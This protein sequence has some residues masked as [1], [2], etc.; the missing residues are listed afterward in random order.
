MWLL[1]KNV[2]FRHL[3][4]EAALEKL[5]LKSAEA[6]FVRCKDYAGIQLVK[7]IS[8]IQNEAIRKAEVKA[9]FKDYEQAEKLYLE[10][11]RM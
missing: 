6:A 2:N 3:L 7:R 10:S 11:D 9:Y 5:D 8:S 4:A 1:T